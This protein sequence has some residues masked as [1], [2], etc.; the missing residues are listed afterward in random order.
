MREPHK[1]FRPDL[2][3]TRFLEGTVLKNR[4]DK[5]TA[6]LLA[7]A[8]L[9]GGLG[10]ATPAMAAPATP[11]PEPTITLPA[12]PATGKD[13]PQPAPVTWTL[14]GTTLEAGGGRDAHRHTARVQHETRQIESHRLGRHRNHAHAR[15]PRGNPSQARPDLRHRH[16]HRSEDGHAI[17]P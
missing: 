16:A 7:A 3:H 11:K 17:R 1:G 5:P 10:L 6:T 8:T 12:D 15:K 2:I 14:L 9:V 13:E 4:I